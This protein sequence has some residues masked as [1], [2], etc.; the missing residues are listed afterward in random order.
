MSPDDKNTTSLNETEQVEVEGLLGNL[1]SKSKMAAGPQSVT[2]FEVDVSNETLPGP[3]D[4]AILMFDRRMEEMRVSKQA[5]QDQL[6]EIDD[7]CTKAL[8]ARGFKDVT[9][10]HPVSKV[11]A[12][13]NLLTKKK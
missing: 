5:Y 7:L 6:T 10:F 3:P 4:S 12:V 8:Q 9:L 1:Q 11:R 13:L 2:S